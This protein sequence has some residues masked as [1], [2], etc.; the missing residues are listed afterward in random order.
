MTALYS[1]WRVGVRF[2]LGVFA[3]DECAIEGVEGSHDIGHCAL[4][5]SNTMPREEKE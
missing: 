4:Y 1:T 5:A 3:V 2:E